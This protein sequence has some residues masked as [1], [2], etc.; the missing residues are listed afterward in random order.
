MKTDNTH[1]HG[2]LQTIADGETVILDPPENPRTD[3]G[4]VDGKM[5][6]DRLT[7]REIDVLQLVAKGKL[8]K[9]AAS[10]LHISIKTVEKHRENI[11]KKL[12]IRGI[13]GLTHFAI[14]TGITPCNPWMAME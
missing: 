13:A 2:G 4:N 11:V 1:A 6:I 14:H 12:G 5:Q 10:E 8:N 9:Q 7:S 3:N